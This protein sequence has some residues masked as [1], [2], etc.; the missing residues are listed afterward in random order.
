VRERVD[1]GQL[2]H[3]LGQQTQRPAGASFGRRR[4]GQRDQVRLLGA[5]E[6]VLVG[7]FSTPVRAQGGGEPLLDKASAH[8]LDSG[9]PSVERRGNALVRPAR[10]FFGLI[11]LE[12]DLSVL[13]LANIGLAAC[14]QPLKLVAF[15][16]RERHPILLGH[17]RP[18]GAASL[19]T[20]KRSPPSPQP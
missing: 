7:A 9:D 2:H 14:E 10:S 11:G 15:V 16:S 20:S 17:D 4:A 6:L 13:D 12:Q 1:I 5:V 3:A 19:L 8:A 18:P